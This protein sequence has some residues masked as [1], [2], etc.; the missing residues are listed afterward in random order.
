LGARAW[1]FDLLVGAKVS[2]L[3]RYFG[4]I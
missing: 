3:D 1:N 4:G 2:N